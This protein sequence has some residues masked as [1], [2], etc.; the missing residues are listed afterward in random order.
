MTR[1]QLKVIRLIE[2]D[3]CKECRFSDMATVTL[4]N[5]EVQT[6]IHCRRMDCDNWDYQDAEDAE[7]MSL[8][9]EAA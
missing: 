5:G 8:E 6:M 4:A 9:S 3:L 7:A 2:P 1:K